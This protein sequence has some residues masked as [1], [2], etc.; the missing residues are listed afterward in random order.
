[1]DFIAIIGIIEQV[2]SVIMKG[3]PFVEELFSGQDNSGA[4]KAATVLNMAKTVVVGVGD[5]D[6]GKGDTWKIIE[7]LAVNFINDAVAA[8][9]AI[10]TVQAAK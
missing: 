8:C 7:P 5:T 2:A 6:A 1:M 10:Q 3:I 4:A 9:R